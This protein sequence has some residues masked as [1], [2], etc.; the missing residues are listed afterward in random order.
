LS[1]NHYDVLSIYLDNETWK[2]IA[3][4]PAVLVGN[5]KS[6]SISALMAPC[7][8]LGECSLSSPIYGS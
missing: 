1:E 4:P 2:V 5:K 7:A 8:W 3:G 6:I